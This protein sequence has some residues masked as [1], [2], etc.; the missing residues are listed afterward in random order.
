MFRSGFLLMCMAA[1]WSAHA[2]PLT[3]QAAL[4]LA[5]RTAPEAELQSSAVEQATAAAEAA[6]RLPDP[7]LALAIENLPIEG[8]DRFSLTRDF[9]TMRKVGLMQEVPN[10]GKRHAEA[11]IAVA[12]IDKAQLER[13]TRLLT[14]RRDTALA[15]L[16]RFHTERRIAL[17]DALERENELFAQA[18]QAQFLSGNSGAADALIARQEA[19]ELAD[20]RDE[21]MRDIAQA[22]NG[23]RRWIGSAA[24]EPI[25]GDAPALQLDAERL[26]AHVHQHP[27]LTVFAPM[28][29]L[30][31]A[32]VHAAEAAK[33]P[34]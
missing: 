21:L 17:F 1:A 2:E 24:D 26:R 15:W 28:T 10:R 11:D 19:A 5:V 4:E 22:R 12:A 3:L 16:T 7:K 6:G 34:D 29:E 30:A 13:H 8:D 20:R 31:Q 14:I 32:E 25:A 23:L 27:E 9:M 33:R 18:V